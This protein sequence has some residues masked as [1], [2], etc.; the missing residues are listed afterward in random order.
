MNFNLVEMYNGLLRF[1]KHILNELAGGLGAGVTNLILQKWLAFNGGNPIVQTYWTAEHN[2]GN[3]STNGDHYELGKYNTDGSNFNTYPAV[4]R[5]ILNFFGDIWTFIRDVAIINRNANYNSIYLLKKGVNHSDITIDN[6]QDK[7]YFIGDQA[8][9]NN[10][11]TE[12]DFRFGP[13]F[14][15]NKVG[16][17][18]KA[19]YNWIRGNNGQDTDKAIRVLLLGGLGDL[20]SKAGSGSFYSHLV[21]SDYATYYG[22]F[23]TVKL[24]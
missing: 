10:F 21:R 16:T 3:G 4:Y 12:F 19:D 24:D 17:N 2:I 6:I 15:P 9:T 20:G 14:V 23:T 11:I 13:Y 22:F 1:N 7:C 5:G 8:N 18:K